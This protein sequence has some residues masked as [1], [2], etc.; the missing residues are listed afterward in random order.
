VRAGAVLGDTVL[1]LDGLE[2]GERVATSGSFKLREGA[3][4]AIAAAP[5]AGQGGP[6]E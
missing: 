1:L 5:A 6:Q 2:A 3:L 4:V